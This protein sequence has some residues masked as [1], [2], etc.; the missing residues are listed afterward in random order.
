MTLTYSQVIKMSLC[1][2][3]LAADSNCVLPAFAQP[4]HMTWDG[5]ILTAWT[6][7]VLSFSWWLLPY[8]LL[9]D[10]L[11]EL[12]VASC[13]KKH[14]QPSSV[15]CEKL[16]S[17]TGQPCHHSLASDGSHCGPCDPVVRVAL[18]IATI[19]SETSWSHLLGL[20]GGLL[21]PNYVS[22]PVWE[23]PLGS[24]VISYACFS[25]VPPLLWR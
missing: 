13:V 11:F 6:F 21:L 1:K 20:P 18:C 15:L 7:H 14:A 4:S 3:R 10:D 17:S 23:S 16:R 8:V 9:H 12:V 25:R 24:F 5:H 22:T 2:A 19:F